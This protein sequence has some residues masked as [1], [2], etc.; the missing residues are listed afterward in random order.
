MPAT[1]IKLNWLY[2]SKKKKINF[3][4]LHSVTNFHINELTLTSPGLQN[5][6]IPWVS[7]FVFFKKKVVV[8]GGDFCLWS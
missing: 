1:I 3:A 6:S 8:S 5:V 2:K 4:G 7:L